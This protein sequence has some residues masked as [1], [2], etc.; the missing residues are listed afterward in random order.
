MELLE[1]Y[2]AFPHPPLL[3]ENLPTSDTPATVF[4]YKKATKNVHLIAASFPKDFHV[5]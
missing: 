4:A 5:I 2:I 1:W 3:V